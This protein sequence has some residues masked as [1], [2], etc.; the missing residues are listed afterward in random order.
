MTNKNL[1]QSTNYVAIAQ[2]T[3]SIIERGGYFNTS[4]DWCSIR[5]MSASRLYEPFMLQNLVE[6]YDPAIFKIG[7]ISVVGDGPAIT[8]TEETTGMAL[9]RMAK[10][11]PV[12][13]LNFASAKN[14]G[15][16]FLAGSVAQEED[17]ARASTLYEQLRTQTRYY[18]ANRA[19]ENALYTDHLIYT[20]KVV[21]FRDEHLKLLDA[22]F[23]AA[24]I[25]TPAPNVGAL[26]GD[27]G[28]INE[29]ATQISNT[30][31]RRITYI[32]QV[33]QD[34]GQ[35]RLVLGAWGCGVF[36]NDP[37]RVAHSFKVALKKFPGAFDEVCFAIY[38]R[39][40]HQTTLTAFRNM[41]EE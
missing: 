35:R 25:T 30:V 28:T 36:G 13:G 14:P 18:Q 19:A 17:L 7:P 15:G 1:S 41:F 32:L 4:S 6:S 26:Y 38:D 20:P 11:G 16:G 21:F 12:C 29:A 3:L 23:D 9:R 34:N 37:V 31:L 22:P 2:E 10:D 27:K 24:M 40:Q 39:S 33:A 5:D 8:V